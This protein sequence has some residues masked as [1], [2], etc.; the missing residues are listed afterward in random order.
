MCTCFPEIVL[1]TGVIR[2]CLMRIST[3]SVGPE[4]PEVGIARQRGD[5]VESESRLCHRHPGPFGQSAQLRL[6]FA[7]YRIT[8]R[9]LFFFRF[10]LGLVEFSGRLFLSWLFFQAKGD[11]VLM[12]HRLDSRQF[13]HVIRCPARK[14]SN[15]WLGSTTAWCTAA[16]ASKQSAASYKVAN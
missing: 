9:F 13:R 14:R 15:G 4:T 2:S 6:P 7:M 8:F 12:P 3:R 5:R 16:T 11:R 10:E 1:P